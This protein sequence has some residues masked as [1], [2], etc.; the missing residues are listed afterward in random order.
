MSDSFDIVVVGGGSAGGAMAARLAEDGRFSVLLLEA[1]ASDRHPFTRIPAANI[2]AV[3]NPDFDFCYQVEPDPS[4]NGRADVWP[5]ARRLGGGSSINAMIFIRGHPWDYDHWAEQGATGWDYASV[6]PYF[7][8]LETN[9]RGGDAWRG[10][11]GP[12]SVSEGRAVYPLTRSWI[13]AAV[14][15]GIPRSADLNGKDA[16]GVDLIQ[17]SQHKGWRHST[18]AAY[19][20]PAMRRPNLKVELQAPARRVLIEHGRA[21]GVEFA[22][23]GQTRTVT[24]RRAVVVC[25]GSMNTPRLLMLS[26]VGPAD[27]LKEMGIPVAAD[28]PGVGSNLQEHIGSHVVDQVN[29]RTLNNDLGALRAL[30]HGLNFLLDGR[31]ALTS[32]IGHAQA[33]VRTRPD[34][35]APNIQLQFAPLAFDLNAQGKLELRK[36]SSANTAV[37]VTRPK[38]RGTLRLRSPDPA[39]PPVIRHQLLGDEDDL[40]QLAEGMELARRIFAQPAFAAYAVEEVRPGPPFQDREALKGFLR[41][42]SIPMYHPVGTCRMGSG[43]MA[44]VDPQLRVRGVDGLFVADA[45]IMPSL[46]AGNTNATAIMIGE[47]GSDLVRQALSN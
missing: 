19:V 5:A 44:V 30:G 4:L 26:G 42:A 7:K 38:S 40:E 20:R 28:L 18:A 46:P 15:A 47:K 2:R 10:D 29:A 31:G 11:K 21:T 3:Q 9:E 14:Q 43:P 25:A 6:L 34:L 41:M 12:V 45:S 16:E 33:F 27:H 37:C 36:D 1:G 22:Q 13:E 35:P 17:V 39:D 8:R 32:S 24:A 23:N